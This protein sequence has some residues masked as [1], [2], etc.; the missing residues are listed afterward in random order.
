MKRVRI[1]TLVALPA[2]VAASVAQAPKTPQLRW[3]GLERKEL[4]GTFNG[5]YYRVILRA[6]NAKG[7]GRRI[8][9]DTASDPSIA[10]DGFLINGAETYGFD[11]IYKD[12]VPKGHTA[13]KVLEERA[14]EVI[15]FDVWM[16]G[17]RVRVPRSKHETMLMPRLDT[18]SAELSKD[19]KQ[20]KVILS[21]S[22]GAG[23]WTA[24]WTIRRTGKV[25]LNIGVGG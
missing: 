21:G 17:K 12:W 9:F 14:T 22:D 23:S 18:A 25:E 5:H 24:L 3:G 4:K 10:S 15:Q 11:G 13:R 20:L 19:G 1:T 7:G 2:L 16:D 6:Q 8:T